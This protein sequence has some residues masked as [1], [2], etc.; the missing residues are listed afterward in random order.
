MVIVG[1]VFGLVGIMTLSCFIVEVNMMSNN[2][3]IDN[4]RGG[5]K[6]AILTVNK[7]KSFIIKNNK[8]RDFIKESN[9]NK[10][11]DSFIK[12]CQETVRMFNKDKYINEELKKA[13]VKRED[14]DRWVN[15]LKEEYKRENGK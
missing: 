6:M 4:I 11:S 1:I 10:V 3:Y 7:P 13:N 2:N 12:E 9:E 14:F 15:I 5:E 8:D